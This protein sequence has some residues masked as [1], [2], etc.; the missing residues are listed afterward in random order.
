MKR[1]KL[2]GQTSGYGLWICGRVGIRINYEKRPELKVEM[3]PLVA[4]AKS[5]WGCKWGYRCISSNG[6]KI[7]AAA[8][9]GRGTGSNNEPRANSTA[10]PPLREGLD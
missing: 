8:L 3:G 4:S 6:R 7:S 2:V 10:T 1:E 5:T 9:H